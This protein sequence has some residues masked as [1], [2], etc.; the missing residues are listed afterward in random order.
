M[1]I[2]VNTDSLKK[3]VSTASS[4][5]NKDS[6]RYVYTKLKFC[7]E[8]NKLRVSAYSEQSAA[9]IFIDAKEVDT[10]N[11]YSIGLVDPDLCKNILTLSDQDT[12]IEFTDKNIIIESF[13]SFTLQSNKDIEEA[14]ELV[15]LTGNSIKIDKKHLTTIA[16][17]E[18][19]ASDVFSSNSQMNGVR[20]KLENNLL[21]ITATDSNVLL[22]TEYTDITGDD[23]D[24]IIPK[25]GLSLI[26]K[27]DNISEL[28]ISDNRIEWSG[29]D[30]IIQYILLEGT[31][32]P[33]ERLLSSLTKDFEF[34]ISRPKLET[35]FK[36]AL[37]LAE[38]SY[39]ASL[40][41]DN[42]SMIIEMKKA[43]RGKN[44]TTIEVGGTF[45]KCTLLL[46][47]KRFLDYL[48]I[49]KSDELTITV[50]DK[51]SNG[52]RPLLVLDSEINKKFLIVSEIH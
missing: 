40:L 28:R 2:E 15:P 6:Y 7:Y 50:M 13:S 48:K 51:L 47:A 14:V 49:A 25:I 30:I 41:L 9:T 36:S 34:I 46:N 16:T 22:H 17:S 42:N 32:P 29:S 21:S 12:E 43:G 31:Y 44:K 27:I 24:C 26:N 52:S 35:A 18:L 8:N 3:A 37:L 38:D 20:V 1:R 39:T 33:I 19:F 5:L 4:F 11:P 45:N 23:F 10:S